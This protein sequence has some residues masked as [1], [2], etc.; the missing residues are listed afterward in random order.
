MHVSVPDLYVFRSK[1]VWLGS[2]MAPSTE[3][4]RME[5]TTA[6]PAAAF[7]PRLK[8]AP[9]ALRAP[10]R[11]R[12]CLARVPTTLSG[13]PFPR[14]RYSSKLVFSDLDGPMKSGT[15]LELRWCCSLVL[16]LAREVGCGAGAAWV[17]AAGEG[18]SRGGGF[19]RDSSS[20]SAVASCCKAWRAISWDTDV[21]KGLMPR[22]RRRKTMPSWLWAAPGVLASEGVFG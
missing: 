15:E 16:S 5:D 21:V 14:W 4:P 1:M 10:W 18:T 8:M 13:E 17:G 2:T 22:D 6:R 9:V 19:L 20:E 7:W 11:S 3:P 12:T